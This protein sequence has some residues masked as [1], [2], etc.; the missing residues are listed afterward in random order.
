MIESCIVIACT[1]L[2]LF[3][4]LQLS[5]LLAAKE[6]LT[7]AAARGARA[8][9]VGFNRWMVNKVVDVAAIPN[10]GRM[11]V[12]D[13]ENV[14]GAL[15]A[16]VASAHPGDTWNYALRTEPASV[17]AALEH[18]RIPEYLAAE[19]PARARYILDYD[20]WDTIGY[21]AHNSTDDPGNAPLVRL[22]AYQD[23]PL[24]VPLHRA[25]YAADTL[26]LS[27]DATLESHYP[28]YLDDQ[29]W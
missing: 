11:R 26:S 1:A 4:A 19:N 24:W 18:A 23:Y 27:A 14:N 20:N 12:P 29:D 2:L 7:H 10:A 3:G 21:W 25:F 5:Q 9:T 28:L 17:Q 13:Y 6:I 15:R 8:K 16:L 22:H